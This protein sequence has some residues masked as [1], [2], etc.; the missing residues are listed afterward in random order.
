MNEDLRPRL[1]VLILISSLSLADPHLAGL[2]RGRTAPLPGPSSLGSQR[3]A[4][5]P[6]SKDLPEAGSEVQHDELLIEHSSSPPIFPTCSTA[7]HS[8][9]IVPRM[10]ARRAD[11]ASPS[12]P[13]AADG[14]EGGGYDGWRMPIDYN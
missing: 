6:G 9:L 12:W 3:C 5:C 14:K 8:V 10:E 11:S 2:L 7:P 4:G 13:A 1:Q